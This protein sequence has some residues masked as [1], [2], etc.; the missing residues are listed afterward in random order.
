MKKVLL[1]TLTVMAL[2]G[3]KVDTDYSLEAT[4]EQL[5]TIC[6]AFGGLPSTM[7]LTYFVDDR[8]WAG[9]CIN[10][11]TGATFNVYFKGVLK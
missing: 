1:A 10:P 6:A 9:T 5:K 4:R 8:P 3:C 11:N 7:Q 2:A